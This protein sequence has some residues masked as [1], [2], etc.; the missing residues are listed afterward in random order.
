VK[1]L[2]TFVL[3]G[4]ILVSA[5]SPSPEAP[6]GLNHRSNAVADHATPRALL[7]SWLLD[8]KAANILAGD[9]I[10]NYRMRTKPQ[11]CITLL[12]ALPVTI[13]NDIEFRIH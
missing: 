2:I 12:T 9:R 10:F 4:L 1:I 6:A 3:P 8:C 5:V 11:T 13:C 7:S